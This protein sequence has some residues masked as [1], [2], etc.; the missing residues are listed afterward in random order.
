MKGAPQESVRSDQRVGPT[1]RERESA[2]NA[3]PVPSDPSRPGSG[4]A[5]GIAGSRHTVRNRL[6]LNA[7]ALANELNAPHS[8][9]SFA[10]G[11]HSSIPMPE[12]VATERPCSPES[13]RT[14][15]AYS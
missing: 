8:E 7:G 6:T 5:N 2:R 4:F 3:T 14:R 13:E 9:M 15:I 11:V 10:Y 1:A 12:R